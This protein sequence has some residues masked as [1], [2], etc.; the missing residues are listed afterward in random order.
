MIRKPTI[1]VIAGVIS[2]AVA[3]GA[4]TL[5][6]TDHPKFCA[7]C[8]T[9]RPSYESWVTSTHKEVTCVDC[10]VR[11]GVGGFIEDKAVAGTKD[12]LIT[13]F[14]TPSEPH[15]LEAR[16]ESNVCLG[17]HRAILRVSEV[18]TRDLPAPV[19]DVGLIM[20]HRQHMEAF[21]KRGRG[22][23]CTTCH[24]QV[25]HGTPIKGYPIVIPRGHVKSDSEP[26]YP[27]YPEGSKLWK[28]AL[29]DCF[30]CHDGKSVHEG[31]VLD[32]K[33]ETCHIPD[34]ISSFLLF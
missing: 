15:N 10:H 3:L 21:A 1:L 7:S 32:Q 22:E 26:H 12:V 29:A 2:G 6:L 11:P 28:A 16:V 13:L 5:P 20:S 17:C 23:G 24:S 8:H 18:S 14:G 30:R 25:V 27:D 9:I 4:V 33:C 34:K 19:K 31:K